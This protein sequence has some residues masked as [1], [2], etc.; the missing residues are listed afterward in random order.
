MNPRSGS[1]RHASNA[2]RPATGTDRWFSIKSQ[3]HSRLLNSLSP[4]QLRAL[5]K[6]GVR[7]QVGIV[8]E[9]LVRDD[10]IPM[11]VPERDRLVEEVLDEV[12]G[13]GPLEPLLKDP[14]VSDILVN[15][16]DCVYVERGGRLTE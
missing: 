2:S 3:L 16:Y 10:N 9:R 8:V 11:T 14:S 4:D 12:F 6:D 1:P 15:G 7:E 5:N 13:L